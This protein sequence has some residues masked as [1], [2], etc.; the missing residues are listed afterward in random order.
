M[1]PP[2]ILPDYRGSRS[3]ADDNTTAKVW[4][5]GFSV[6]PTRHE[7]IVYFSYYRREGPVLWPPVPCTG[8]QTLE[9]VQTS[10]A[11]T[12][13]VTPHITGC[14]RTLRAARTDKTK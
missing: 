10:S 6:V 1:G 8:W 11:M 9:A 13:N 4:Q 14:S 12:R 3:D 2:R 5:R 7:V